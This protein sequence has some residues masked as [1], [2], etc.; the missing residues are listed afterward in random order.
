MLVAWQEQLLTKGK[1][2]AQDCKVLWG[3]SQMVLPRAAQSNDCLQYFEL[4]RRLASRCI[5]DVITITMSYCL[6]MLT[7]PKAAALFFVPSVEGADTFCLPS[8]LRTFAHRYLPWGKSQRKGRQEMQRRA[9]NKRAT[10][11]A[12]AWP[13]APGESELVSGDRNCGGGDH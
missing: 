1:D 8:A 6:L 2:S 13:K 10:S 4:P 5:L 7:R 12:I 9:G 3:N 11:S